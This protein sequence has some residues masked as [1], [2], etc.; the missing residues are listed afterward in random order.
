VKA[1]VFFAAIVP[2]VAHFMWQPSA[3]V[4]S[5]V[6]AVSVLSN[7]SGPRYLGRTWR[8]GSA[9]EMEVRALFY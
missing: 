3:E 9:K 4:L 1:S 7:Y 6:K 2:K 5:A 8:P